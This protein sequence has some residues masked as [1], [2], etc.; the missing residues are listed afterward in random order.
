M[1]GSQVEIRRIQSKLRQ[2]GQKHPYRSANPP[3]SADAPVIGTQAQSIN[4]QTANKLQRGN[5]TGVRPGFDVNGAVSEA[6][7]ADPSLQR[8][9]ADL[10]NTAAGRQARIAMAQVSPVRG[11][12]TQVPSTNQAP[13]LSL[14]YRPALA[15]ANEKMA[16]Q[17]A[18][19]L[20]AQLR[21]RYATHQRAGNPWVNNPENPRTSSQ[22]QPTAIAPITKLLLEQW[23]HLQAQ[24]HRSPQPLE[25]AIDN[26]EN[27]AEDDDS[28]Y[29]SS[30]E[31]QYSRRFVLPQ[32]VRWF[33]GAIIARVM[34]DGLL[35]LFPSLLLVVMTVV[36]TPVA[37]A[38]Y[39]TA[40]NP[41]GS[42]HSG[43]RL[44]VIMMGLLI[45]G[46]L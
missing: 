22:F 44:L 45:G 26:T 35:S 27:E 39:Q 4:A 14:P 38:L 16:H 20:A 5:A 6:L 34:I 2:I 10:Y 8:T 21:Q 12:A 3:K 33:V 15:T 28:H 30:S 42:V 32:A 41:Q 18:D 40:V 13:N 7:S 11:V 1:H 43:R 19:A 9:T 24:W 25:S 46:Q 17:H 36:L 23:Q 31:P 29:S 37:I